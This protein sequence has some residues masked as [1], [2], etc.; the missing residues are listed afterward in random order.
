MKYFL[1]LINTRCADLQFIKE[2][3]IQAE[4]LDKAKDFAR[5]VVANWYDDGHGA[6]NCELDIDVVAWFDNGTTARCDR[7]TEISQ[8]EYSTFKKYGI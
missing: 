7:I 3:T 1:L 8:S 2:V 6:E 4:T 5:E